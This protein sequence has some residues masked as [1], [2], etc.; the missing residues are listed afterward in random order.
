MK[1]VVDASV[2]VK[3]FL[4][5]TPD[6]DQANL[7]L[8]ILESSACGAAQLVEPV[9]FIAEV[10]AV[11][12]RLRPAE[13]QVDLANLLNLGLRTLDSPEIYTT[14]LKLSQRHGH[15]LF[16]TLYHAVALHT[17]GARLVTA[18]QRYYDKARVDGRMMLLANWRFDA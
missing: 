13:A 8:A 1:W 18:D 5:V 3:W 12:A 7:A 11:L 15:H 10:T 14:A 2:A 4:P 17:P 9:H 6:E 16:D